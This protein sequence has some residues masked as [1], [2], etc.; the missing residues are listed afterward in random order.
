MTS[1]TL[2]SA[3]RVQ[4][5]LAAIDIH[6][7]TLLEQNEDLFRIFARHLSRSL[8]GR[9]LDRHPPKELIPAIEELLSTSLF[10]E[11][12]E[13]K[14]SL[15]VID[16]GSDRRG[17][18]ITCLPDQ[19][20]IVSV[21][22]QALLY[23]SV[24]Q[25][26][27]FNTVCRVRREATGRMSAVETE[28][29]PPE[30]M[31]W[32]EVEAENLSARR[33]EIETQ[34]SQRLKSII[35][36]VQ[37]Y[38]E[39]RQAMT[40]C[41][42]DFDSLSKQDADNEELHTT[43][44]NFI[45]WLLNE[46]FVI[47]GTRFFGPKNGETIDLGT[48][49]TPAENGI[50][51]SGN[52]EAILG[53]GAQLP[54]LWVRKSKLESWVY[55]QGHLDHIFV[56][57]F[58]KDLKPAGILLVQGL[59]SFQA[60]VEPRTSIPILSETNRQL[61]EGLNAQE[62]THRHRS[63][64][65][66]FNSLPLEYLFALSLKDIRALV[67]QL[68]DADADAGVQVHVT[69]V[70][71]QDFAFAFIV[72]P[73]SFFS[74]DLRADIRNLLR[75]R[76]E[77]RSVDDGVYSGNED[78]VAVHYFVTG[79]K[80]L[81]QP[82]SDS[83]REEI[84]QMAQPWTSRLK[85]ELFTRLSEENARPLYSR[86]REAFPSRYREETSVSRA[87]TDIELLEGLTQDSWFTC[88]IF[89]EKSDKRRGITRLRL[90]HSKSIILSDILPV[91]DNLGLVII[92]QYPTTIHV[93]GRPEAVISTYRIRGTKQMQVDLMSRRNRLS[94]AIRASILG[95]F[96]NDTFN[97]LL[98]RA[99]VPWNYVSLL[100][101]L[102]SY[103]R[104]L[105]SPYGRET[106][107]EALESNSDVVRSLT[108][109]FRIKFD[110]SIEGLDTS[111]VCDK[112]ILLIERAER[113]LLAQIARVADLKSDSIIR[114]FYNLIQATLRTNFY[115]RDP[116]LVPEVVLKFDPS[117]IERIPEPRPYRE[118]YVH[119]PKVAGLHLRGGP[120]A[121]GGI[122]W[123]DR[124]L[125][126]RTEV[127][128]LMNTQNLKNVV[129]VPR[130]A[131]GAFIIRETFETLAEQRAAADAGYKIFINGLLQVTDNL[132]A[133]KIVAP[134]NTLRYDQ[135]DHYLV[136]AAD[137]G[138]AHLSDTANGIGAESDFWLGDAFASGGSNG[139]DH[140]IDGVTAKGA[141]ECVKRHFREMGMHPEKDA[142]KVIG[143]GDMSG[144][145][146]G[147]GMLR[148]SSMQLI[149]A[150][151]HRHIFIDPNPDPAKSYE[152]RQELFDKTRT[153]WM[154]YPSELIS[155][156]GGVWP[157]G[158]K[159]I[160]LPPEAKK[161]LGIEDD[162]LSG[163]DLIQR[164][165]CAPADLLWNGG[166]GTYIK[167]DKES[168]LDA[169]DPNNDSVRINA[170]QVRVKVIGEGGNLGI[171]AQG[172]CQ[173]ASQGVRLNTDAVDNSGGVDLSDH[174][175]NIK[176]LMGIPL[177]HGDV[178]QEE[179]D[180]LLHAVRPGVNKTVL[181]NN[182]VQSRM[183]SL[184]QLRSQR[185]LPR[186]QRAIEHLSEELGFTRQSM[187][188]PSNADLEVRIKRG[189]GLYRPELAVLASNSKL[190]MRTRL[191]EASEFNVERLE[192]YLLSYFPDELVE[193]FED[194]IKQ[195]PLALDIAQAV[196]TNLVLGD[197]GCTFITEMMTQTGH[198]CRSI[199]D[200]YLRAAELL[201]STGLKQSIPDVEFELESTIEYLIRLQIEQALERSTG[202]LL[203]R[204]VQ[205]EKLFNTTFKAVL[206]NM[207][208]L[209]PK[210]DEDT[211]SAAAVDL[212]GVGLPQA[213]ADEL[214]KFEHLDEVLD[215]SQLIL[216][217]GEHADRAA[218]IFYHVGN[219]TGLL[220]LVRNSE[221][222]YNTSKLEK[223]AR[224]ALRDQLRMHHVNLANQILKGNNGH[225][226]TGG[227]ERMLEA[228]RDDLIAVTRGRLD[229]STLV[230]AADRVGRYTHS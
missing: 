134:I 110:P 106:V 131:K 84:S 159:S 92:D 176:I 68:L 21:I 201:N 24:R 135:D 120:V 79:I 85:N 99:D 207:G 215:L 166:I 149:A 158:A 102:H 161:V 202:W 130:G 7:P 188:L 230:I 51:L 27:S 107:R 129:I 53:G 169:S 119:H 36:S 65:K 3:D 43:N 221:Q 56:Q 180:R 105:G 93:S 123:S 143:I 58:D 70:E 226:T 111:N 15:Q 96:D 206:A 167:S 97:R 212:M 168:D 151:D 26:R 209:I 145:V 76:M 59:F 178:T 94:S 69:T 19:P 50:P 177:E 82:D 40:A 224:T 204:H 175:V 38:S 57:C 122:R 75:K 100:Q 225:G 104:Q 18:L 125:D 144:D 60:L 10:R 86:Y 194:A 37:D 164:L 30:A 14:V 28:G 33:D 23:N 67:E 229:L 196:F 35:V 66:A 154:D 210:E 81:S 189:E 48:A 218:E 141:W 9:Y 44:S 138:T 182:W 25:L 222:S 5:F 22:K 45:D 184:D 137:K 87:V 139:Y 217:S 98:L 12:N 146:F 54:Y 136:V 64:R 108:E 74:D 173:L 31:M 192:Q 118:I 185:D 186:F 190:F 112:R 2:R 191:A 150:F 203:R 156:G 157:R 113:T 34:I 163:P 80:K 42:Q 223:P 181:H 6:E 55:R 88:E 91:L 16:D 171:T 142:I 193:R 165:L 147:N 61:L 41:A 39:M 228:V 1:K 208:S 160:T 95:V 140:K 213:E 62:G 13:I 116:Y 219:S 90:V 183:I 187:Q 124:R 114:T 83:L 198:S 152:A 29:S 32:L 220:K 49:K 103:G 197:A 179:R 155:E 170:G 52:E 195:H 162:E 127:L 71:E 214:S 126:Y 4:A 89:R 109:Y 121:R 133:D 63:I 47:L 128:G 211:R 132:I 73:R 227:T 17:T 205:D 77:G 199:I 46:H 101:A 78:T 174:E 200:S 216:L 153:N 8:D 117:Q 148:S 20:F 172:R 11:P 115:N 72:L